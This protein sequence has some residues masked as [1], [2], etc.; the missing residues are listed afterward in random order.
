MTRCSRLI[1]FLRVFGQ[2]RFQR[3]GLD[4]FADQDARRD[5]VVEVMLGNEGFQRFG[6]GGAF[7][8]LREE[9]AVTQMPSAANHGQVD[10]DHAGHLGHGHHVGIGFAAGGV[11]ELFL[12]Q[13]GQHAQAV[14]QQRGGFEVERGGGGVHLLG[15][16]VDQ[17]GGLAAQQLGGFA[18]IARIGFRRDA[19][20][21]GC[22][23]ALDLVQ[24]AG[25]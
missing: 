3:V 9:A 14:A 19:L 11:D 16:V 13:R 7:A 18:D 15:D 1:F 12:A 24:Q 21:A 22:S 25:P 4:R 2:Q 17:L 5:R 23:A 8:V 10:R 6:Q 20:D